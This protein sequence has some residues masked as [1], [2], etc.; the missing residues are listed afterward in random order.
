VNE[1][2]EEQQGCDK[3]DGEF[4]SGQNTGMGWSDPTF[5]HGS[6]AKLIPGVAPAQQEVSFGRG[7]NLGKEGEEGRNYVLQLRLHHLLHLV[8]CSSF[9]KTGE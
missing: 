2:V 5:A 7:E 8:M 9:G 3:R 4:G 1:S 6:V